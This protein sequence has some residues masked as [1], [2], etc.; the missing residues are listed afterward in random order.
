MIPFMAFVIAVAVH[1]DP[2]KH[3]TAMTYTFAHALVFI[4]WTAL[5]CIAI[6]DLRRMSRRFEERGLSTPLGSHY[7]IQAG[8]GRAAAVS[9][10]LVAMLVS[11]VVVQLLD[12]LNF[13]V[14][15]IYAYAWQFDDMSPE[16][17]ESVVEPRSEISNAA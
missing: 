9:M 15:V 10:I 14:L 17:R 1:L 8:A 11:L 16:D 6:P 13:M 2:F 5:G 3:L 7:G 4:V 12:T